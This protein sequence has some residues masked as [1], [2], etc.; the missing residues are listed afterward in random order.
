MERALGV[1]ESFDV[2]TVV[3]LRRDLSPRPDGFGQ[4]PASTWAM[5][6]LAI[7]ATG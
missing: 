6:I 1:P 4:R 2:R 3:S 7:I 5:M